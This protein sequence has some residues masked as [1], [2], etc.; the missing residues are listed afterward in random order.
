LPLL[1]IG[2]CAYSPECFRARLPDD[3]KVGT[4]PPG[5]LEGAHIRRRATTEDERRPICHERT[6]DGYRRAALTIIV[7]RPG[8]GSRSR[9]RLDLMVST[10]AS[11]KPLG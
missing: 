9:R 11:R 8:A 2:A 10:G 6:V 7:A 4:S 3:S 1:S 5:Q